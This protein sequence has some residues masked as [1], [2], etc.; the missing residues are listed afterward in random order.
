MLPAQWNETRLEGSERVLLG[1]NR[2]VDGQ[3]RF[4]LLRFGGAGGLGAPRPPRLLN[5]PLQ[6]G[7]TSPLRVVR[8]RQ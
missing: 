2:V 4:V 6:L 3:H 7:D 1:G 8:V 5:Q